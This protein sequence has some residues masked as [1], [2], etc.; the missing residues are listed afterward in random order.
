MAFLDRQP[1][2]LPPAGLEIGERL[3]TTAPEFLI[4]PLALFWKRATAGRIGCA[5]R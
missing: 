2:A 3:T 4:F 1:L 5:T